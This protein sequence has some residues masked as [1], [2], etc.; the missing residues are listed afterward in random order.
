MPIPAQANIPLVSI[1]V[2]VYNE[3]R[4]LGQTIDSLLAQDYPHLEFI[5]SDNASTD[6]T[7]EICERTSELDARVR[8]LRSESNLGSSANF[9]RCLDEANGEWF[10]WAGGHDLWSHDMISRCVAAL[11]VHPGAVVAVPESGWIDAESRPFGARASI[12]DTR[13]MEPLARV[14]TILWA[15]MHPM[16][17]VIRTEALRS[18]CPVPNYPGADLILLVRLILQGD[19]VPA[20][21]AT[22]FRRQV[23]ERETHRDRRLRYRGSHFKIGNRRFPLARLATEFLKAVWSSELP[24]ADRIV[25]AVAFPWLLP[26]RYIVAKRRVA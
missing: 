25:F 6:G 21:G 2:P 15:N 14:F 1:G 11:Q 19:F 10:L 8:V 18:A 5:V 24:L 7:L 16:Y 23:R 22:W 4:F 3:A 13:G 20:P 9:Q 26:A 17:G 12:L